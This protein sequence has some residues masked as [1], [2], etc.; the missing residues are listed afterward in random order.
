M[1]AKMK[2]KIETIM[3]MDAI[4][5]ES[6][7]PCMFAKWAE[8]VRHFDKHFPQFKGVRKDRHD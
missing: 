2:N 1:G 3:E 7:S 5:C 6:L 8:I 4:A